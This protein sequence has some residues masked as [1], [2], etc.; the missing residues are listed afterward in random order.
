[1]LSTRVHG[2]SHSPLARALPPHGCPLS[3][4]SDWNS[5]SNRRRAPLASP[6]WPLPLSSRHLSSSPSVPC[7]LRFPPRQARFSCPR[8][9][10][11]ARSGVAEGLS[12]GCEAE[13]GGSV[14]CESRSRGSGGS[15]GGCIPPPRPGDHELC[16]VGGEVPAPAGR[17]RRARLCLLLQRRQPHGRARPLKPPPRVLSSTF[18]LDLEVGSWGLQEGTW[19]QLDLD[20]ELQKVVWTWK[21][22]VRGDL[23]PGGER[24]PGADAGG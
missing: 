21:L 4:C 22:E 14:G 2:T 23:E 9:L 19:R 12:G 11:I 1:M 13:T 24:R 5:Q 6:P 18:V 10:R 8:L 20:L 3:L 16:Y 17:P 15:F 7:S